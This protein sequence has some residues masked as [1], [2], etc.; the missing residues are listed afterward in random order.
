MRPRQAG[1]VELHSR[2]IKAGA[3]PRRHHTNTLYYEPHQLTAL[4]EVCVGPQAPGIGMQDD[5]LLALAINLAVESLDFP[6]QPRPDRAVP[7]VADGAS[8]V[9]L[10]VEDLHAAL[11]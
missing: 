11:C 7:A 8:H 6:L 1:D 10:V 5:P 3:P 4:A 9:V 2:R